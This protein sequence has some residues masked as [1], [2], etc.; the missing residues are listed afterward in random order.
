MNDLIV[1]YSLSKKIKITSLVAGIFLTM[2]SVGIAVQQTLASKFSFFFVV[3]VLGALIG[4]VLILIVVYHPDELQ[5]EINNEHFRIK[6][7]KQRIDG[8]IEWENVTQ[9]GIGLSYLV[10]TTQGK[11]YKIDLGNL[12]YNDIKLIKTKLLEICEAKSIAYSNL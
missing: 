11:T 7:P 9:V 2:L 1:A 10:L 3:G 6:L 4:V 5:L 8:L 12:K